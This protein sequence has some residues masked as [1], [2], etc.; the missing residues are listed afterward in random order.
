M[1]AKKRKPYTLS[2]QQAHTSVLY[3]LV[4]AKN[5]QIGSTDPRPEV[6]L[7]SA[8]FHHDSSTPPTSIDGIWWRDPK[9]PPPPQTKKKE[10][11]YKFHGRVAGKKKA[12]P[13]QCLGAPVTSYQAN[14]ILVDFVWAIFDLFFLGGWISILTSLPKVWVTKNNTTLDQGLVPL[15]RIK[16]IF[17]LTTSGPEL[18][19]EDCC[20]KISAKA[21]YA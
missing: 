3:D 6:A 2:T 21:I 12:H 15:L 4:V 1:M 7:T 18:Y 17:G 13:T 16:T 19:Q 11:P 5:L 14:E 8:G 20:N 9:L 10:H